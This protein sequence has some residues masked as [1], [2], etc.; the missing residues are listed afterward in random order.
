M[1]RSA[2][3]KGQSPLRRQ[4]IS[5]VSIK[6]FDGGRKG[7]VEHQDA[8]ISGRCSVE[9]PLE[10]GL[11]E[12]RL[13]ENCQMGEKRGDLREQTYAQIG[14]FVRKGRGKGPRKRS[15]NMAAYIK[16]RM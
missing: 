6:S 9:A 2:Q 4:V 14:D 13:S 15:A 8:V 12:G 7:K 16:A 11:E 10:K 5:M 3:E 1:A